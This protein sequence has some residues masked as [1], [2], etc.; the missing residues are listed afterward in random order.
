MD[1][2][3]Q[4]LPEWYAPLR[5]EIGR[6]LDRLDEARRDRRPELERERAGLR[7]SLQGLSMSL[8]KPDLD[9][10]LRADIEGQYAGIRQR[11][12]AL[13]AEL[14]GLE[15]RQDRR[16][17][18][19]DPRRVLDRLRRLDEVLARGNVPLGNLELARH[20]DRIDVYPDDRVVMRTSK[21]GVFEGALAV[22]AGEAPPTPADGP[23]PATPRIRPRPRGR[24]RID[25]TSTPGAASPEDVPPG[26]APDRFARVDGKWFW[27]DELEIPPR[28]SW[29]AEHAE[30]VARLR[31]EG[32]TMARLADHF[33]RS[34]P[35]IRH[36]LKLA[37]GGD[38]D[39]IDRPGSPG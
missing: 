11:S 4:S 38:Q 9:P 25:E 34:K 21:L 27:E 33:D 10:C 24:L 26:T 7:A 6:E 1:E 18:L 13:D 37:A 35:T 31:G 15:V 36:A 30:E 3:L 20:I 16:E 5:E 2:Q 39:G 22:L 29:A 19:L 8:A 17:R 14:A 23:T 32:W 28:R 12:V